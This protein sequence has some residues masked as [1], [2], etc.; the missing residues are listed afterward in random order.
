MVS[1]SATILPSSLDSNAASWPSVTH[2]L[3]KPS[4]MID[5]AA[6][7]EDFRLLGADEREQR[8]QIEIRVGFDDLCADAEDLFRQLFVRWRAAYIDGGRLHVRR[9]AERIGYELL[10]I[11]ARHAAGQQQ[12]ST[13]AERP[14]RPR[15]E[16][17]LR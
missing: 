15:M 11:L 2:F 1:R 4:V 8:V 13:D 14:T 12:A 16:P 17:R 9:L 10:Q 3:T 7:M 6:A 5:F